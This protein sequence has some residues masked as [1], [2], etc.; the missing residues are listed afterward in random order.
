MF[1]VDMAVSCRTSTT[2]DEDHQESRVEWRTS[3]LDA[4]NAALPERSGRNQQNL[5]S[6]KRPRCGTVHASDGPVM[7]GS[8]TH[9]RCH[10]PHAL[11]VEDQQLSSKCNK[12]AIPG[13]IFRPIGTHPIAEKAAKV[14]VPSALLL[15]VRCARTRASNNWNVVRPALVDRSASEQNAEVWRSAHTILHTDTD[16]A[17]WTWQDC[18]YEKRVEAPHTSFWVQ[19]DRFLSHGS[20]EEL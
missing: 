20:L 5:A 4:I 6:S 16:S 19:F 8:S 13:N 14:D 12:Q 18:L 7:K 3:N 1:T 9:P 15:P 10:I 11:L 17:H 2:L